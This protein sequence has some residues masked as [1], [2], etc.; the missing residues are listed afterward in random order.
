MNDRIKN[1][2]FLR[3]FFVLLALDQH[4]SYYLNVWY[5]DYFRDS[6]ALKTTYASHFPLIGKTLSVGPIE[7]WLALIFTPWVSQIYL[8]MSAFNLAKRS[9]EDFKGNLSSKLKIFGLIFLF[10]ILENFI[11]APNT[12]E[13]ISF[14]PIM[15]WMI[16]L[17][18]LSVLYKNLGIRAIAALTFISLFRFVVPIDLL[19]DF[20]ESAIKNMFHPGY[21]YDARLEYFI[22]S[23][24]LG[25]FMGHIHYHKFNLRKKKNTYFILSGLF[26]I[27][28]FYFF[29]DKFTIDPSNVFSTEHTLAGTFWGT[30]YILGVQGLVISLFL[31]LEEKNITFNLPVINWIGMNSLLVFSLHRILFVKF[32]A[33]ASAMM[34]NFLGYTLSPSSI[35]LYIYITFTLIICYIIKRTPIIEII[36]QRKG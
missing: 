25:F 15:L 9:Q 13:A 11:V 12:G 20:W 36:F 2:D 16:V 24:C 22:L 21:E 1:L 31:L 19:S 5:L 17:S 27:V 28:L 18:L 8:T 23:G 10:F 34:G 14:Y 26:F 7:Y 4:F 30:L 35:Q 6:M 32:I 29:G 33:P 3:G